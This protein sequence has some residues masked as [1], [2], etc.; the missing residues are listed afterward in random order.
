MVLKK[1]QRAMVTNFKRHQ[2]TDLNF[3]PPK[4]SGEEFDG[5]DEEK[6]LQ[7]SL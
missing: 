7:P 6:A 1:H 4:E 5:R 3:E 2:L